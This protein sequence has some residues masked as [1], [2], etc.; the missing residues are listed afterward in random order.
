MLDLSNQDT[1]FA[2]TD[3][4]VTIMEG[5]AV[6]SERLGNQHPFAAPYDAFEATDGW[7]VVATASN[8]LFRGLCTAIGRPELATDERFRSHRG[9]ARN[10][11]E[12]NA[13]IADW[14][15]KHSCEQV[16]R[17][18]GPEGADL[19]CAR[20]ARPYELVDDPQLVARGMIE[21]HPHP[22]LKEV[23]FH[24]NPLLFSGAERRRL[25]LAPELAEHN[26]EV[27][28]ELGLG[29]EDLAELSEE[30]VI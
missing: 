8:K 19:P 24:G 29:E 14:V 30:G 15:R 22:T 13:T 9:R 17:A 26:R 20:V 1:V 3:S 28:A 2:I 10:R 6:A 21:R 23:V 12:I 4:A 16:L 11:R 25:A 5:I 18:L 27:Y 7:V